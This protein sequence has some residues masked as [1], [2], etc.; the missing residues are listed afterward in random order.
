MSDVSSMVNK[1]ILSEDDSR[2]VKLDTTNYL[3]QLKQDDH[4]LLLEVKTNFGKMSTRDLIRHTYLLD[5]FYATN[6]KIAKNIL[7]ADE[8]KKVDEFNSRK[9]GTILHTI[10]YEGLS[11]EKYLVRLLM[12][13][14]KVLL[15][16]RS[17]P[18]SMK[19]G[20]S[21][22]QLKKYCEFLGI[23]YKHIP[24]LGISSEIR[25]KFKSQRTYEKLFDYYLQNIIPETLELQYHVLNL[26]AEHQSI[27]LTCFE[28]NPHQCHR[29]L[30]AEAIAQ[31]PGFKYEVNH[32]R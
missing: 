13:N 9:Q 21:K 30:L 23:Q 5:P 4:R 14:V 8:L 2:I 3:Q 19:F 18:I 7:T 17:N 31:L 24:E 12:N 10:G 16:V 1:G 25:K 20:F 15:D 29:K 28:A 32:I 22:N 27:A 6:S 11:L 26:L